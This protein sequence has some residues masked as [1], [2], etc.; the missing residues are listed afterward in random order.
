MTAQNELDSKAMGGTELLGDRL[1]KMIDP[2]LMKDFQIIRSRF[3]GFDASKKY[4][5]FWEHDLPG[6]PESVNVFENE[7]TMKQLHAIVFLTV[8]QKNEFI[9]AFPKIPIEKCM[10]IRNGIVPF[11]ILQ[12]ERVD[13]KVHFIYTPTPHRG[14]GL[15]VPVFTA[16]AREFPNKLHLDVYSSFKLYGWEERDAPYQELFKEIKDHP[17]MTYHGTVSNDEIRK[18]LLRSDVFAYPSIWQ[19]TSC[20]CLIEAMSAGLVC[21]CSDL[22]ALPETSGNLACL[23]PYNPEPMI[24]ARD[25]YNICKAVIN[26][27]LNNSGPLKALTRFSKQYCDVLHND[28]VMRSNWTILLKIIKDAP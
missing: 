24:H 26:A 8:W 14:L 12:R 7:E 27:H 2:D 4:H 16:L 28:E 10:V 1:E 21:I 20:L 11:D 6:D 17:D 5:I 3:R 18:A 15:L 25:F 13:D 23:Y 9:R 19:E 22:A